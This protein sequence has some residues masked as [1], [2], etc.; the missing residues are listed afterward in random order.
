MK[1]H[2]LI[3]GDKLAGLAMQHAVEEMHALVI[4]ADE[5]GLDGEGLAGLHF[6]I[7]IEMGLGGEE[8]Q[9]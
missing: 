9:P 1:L 7:V 5:L 8:G 3:G 4:Q 2:D 6:A